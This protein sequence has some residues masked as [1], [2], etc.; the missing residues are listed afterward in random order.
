MKRET[1]FLFLNYFR[2]RIHISIIVLDC[3]LLYYTC[4]LICSEYRVFSSWYTYTTTKSNNE[5][6]SVLILV[7]LV[8]GWVV[9]EF[10]TALSAA[11]RRSVACSGKLLA[12]FNFF[13]EKILP[14]ILTK[15]N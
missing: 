2:Y 8:K 5:V 7:N 12:K 14:S 9:N 6:I 10:T 1:F 15:S 13:G 4:L 3:I 11:R